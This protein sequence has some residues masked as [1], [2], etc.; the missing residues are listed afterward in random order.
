MLKRNRIS[1]EQS[2][3]AI[4]IYSKIAI[5]FV[6]ID[7]KDSLKLCNELKLYAY[8]AY[9]ISCAL[10]YQSPLITLDKGLITSAAQKG[11]QVLEVKT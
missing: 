3:K 5:Q 9:I 4:E 2:I 1:L 7:L 6:D 10:K 11:V 8:D